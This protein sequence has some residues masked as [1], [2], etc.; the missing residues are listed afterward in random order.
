MVD[1][2]SGLIDNCHLHFLLLVT[3]LHY[4]YYHCYYH[5]DQGNVILMATSTGTGWAQL[6]Q[7][8]RSLETQVLYTVSR[9][10]GRAMLI[11][12]DFLD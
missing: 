8:A 4:F 1:V 5:L 6:R 10:G 12:L 7:Q 11:D 3:I 2:L 9:N